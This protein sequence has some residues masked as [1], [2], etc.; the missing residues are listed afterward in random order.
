[1]KLYKTVCP[2]CRKELDIPAKREKIQC[3]KCGEIFKPENSTKDL[4]PSQIMEK[5][6]NNFTQLFEIER[7]EKQGKEFGRYRIVEEIGSGGM[8]KVYKAYDSEL[9]RMVALKLM[10]S[11]E[12]AK[13]AGVQRFLRE[14]RATARLQHPNIVMV[15]DIGQQEGQ[16]FFAMELIE[17]VSLKELLQS[18]SMS[19]RRKIAIFKKI[20]QAVDYAHKQGVIHRDLK[21]ANVMMDKDQNPKVMDF[22]LAKVRKASQKLSQSGIIIG[23]LQ[24]MS[25]EQAEGKTREIDERSD[26]YS[27]GAILYEMLTGMP[28][29]SG[30]T[31]S[32]IIYQ[33]LN[34]DPLTPSKI[35]NR[36]PKELDS[37]CLKA[38]EKGKEKRY[39]SISVLVKD[40]SFFEQ[41]KGV[42]ARS[43]RWNRIMRQH[44]ASFFLLM[45]LLALFLAFYIGQSTRQKVTLTSAKAEIPEE[46]G[47][48][49]LED[50]PSKEEKPLENDNKTEV[51]IKV[52]SEKNPLVAKNEN[53]AEV[54]KEKPVEN[55]NKVE[56]E[57][58]GKDL[59]LKGYRYLGRNIY[60]AG[61]VTKRVDEY[62]HNKT[63]MAFVLVPGGSFMMGSNDGRSGERPVHRVN[64]REF[65]ISKYEVT[66]GQWQKIMGNNPSS[67]KG[68]NKPVEGVSWDDAKK[69]C[70][71]SRLRLPSGA[72]WEYACRAGT[73]SKYYWGGSI[74]KNYAHY[75][76]GNWGSAKNTIDVGNKRPNA[77]GLYDMNG[78]V[79]E[80]CEDK[81]KDNYKGAPTNGSAWINNGA[82]VRVNR[83]GG[84]GTNSVSRLRSAFRNGDSPVLRN[85]SLGF[86]VCAGLSEK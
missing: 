55:N 61:G 11:G 24:Y 16:Y 85:V 1:M 78:N 17:G 3:N 53:E 34:K 9:E 67:F 36:I 20:A 10:L 48:I 43:I 83:G 56:I 49:P 13:K 66:Q 32:N 79:W 15:L 26:I 33:V 72:E 45:M 12:N 69:F 30:E 50:S 51:E 76:E 86:R 2:N 39:Q 31:P 5:E 59:K 62:I 41:G 63:G 80:W 28:P 54:K 47:K 8:G 42:K 57:K 38:L 70:S 81:Y 19:V 7:E 71:K 73:T 22:G 75:S 77:F 35:K 4:T 23:T 64:V 14:A 40:L 18:T 65:L 60:S 27:L 82:L 25:P 44:K 74:D 21:P 37:I 68:A 84:W 58:T 6:G 29:F 52:P 46:D